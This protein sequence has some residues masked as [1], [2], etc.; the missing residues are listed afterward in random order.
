L[1]LNIPL[2]LLQLHCSSRNP[3]HSTT[4]TARWKTTRLFNSSTQ[5]G[6]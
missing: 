5:R 1:N 4:R 3:T 2:Q 6:V